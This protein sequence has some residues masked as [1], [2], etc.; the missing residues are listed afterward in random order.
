MTPLENSPQHDAKSSPVVN[1][2]LVAAAFVIVIAGLQAAKSIV[3]PFLLAMFIGIII[4]SILDW[5]RTRGINTTS[6]A[7][8]II[9]MLG[10]AGIFLIPLIAAT[11]NEFGQ[12]LGDYQ[13]TSRE[14][15]RTLLDWAASYGFKTSR[16]MEVQIFEYFAP[17]RSMASV[18]TS[19]TGVFNYAFMVFLM[20][21][22][23]LLEWSK[24]A[25][26][27]ELLPGNTQQTLDRITELMTSIR[28]YMM[29]KTLVSMLT[30]G[31]IFLWLVALDQMVFD[32]RYILLWSTLAF[33]LNFIP[34][35]GSLVAGVLATVFVLV[36]DGVVPAIH[37]SIAFLTVNTV[38]GNMLEP[39][40]MGE[41]L[42]LSTLVVFLSLIFW[43]WV[44]GPAGML[45]AVPLTM[46]CKI[47]LATDQ[48]TAWIAML[49]SAR[50]KKAD[51]TQLR[52]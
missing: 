18:L 5:L 17:G 22:F 13:V 33:L 11:I 38:I 10:M 34:T 23:M 46:T 12:D 35:I 21:A 26:K 49:L 30:G 4:T 44:L 14:R 19:L 7:F 3:V 24:F 31:L 47:A 43:G 25:E 50:V 39:R 15:I 40:I 36:Q 37:V 20:L 9:S 32:V 51:P 48:R 8:L 45:L 28:Q 1:A 2:I 16:D 41:G 6:A 42:G 52:S 27:I 29:I